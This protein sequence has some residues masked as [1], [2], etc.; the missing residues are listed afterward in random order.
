VA[1]QTYMSVEDIL[2]LEGDDFRRAI[3]L[4]VEDM[5]TRVWRP[6][7]E[8][9]YRAGVFRWFR[10]ENVVDL[11]KVYRTKRQA[12]GQV[13]APETGQRG[14]VVQFP[15]SRTSVGR[16]PWGHSHEKR[17]FNGIANKRGGSCLRG[18]D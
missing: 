6:D 5:L 14:V 13:R 10:S 9:E 11:L 17:I 2:A 12:I 1:T 3:T 8:R 18:T 15:H 7:L 16:Q 4:P